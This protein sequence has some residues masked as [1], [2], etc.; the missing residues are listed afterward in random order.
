M[1]DTRMGRTF[2]A[3]RLVHPFPSF[4]N[5]ALVFGLALLAAHGTERPP[6][7]VAGTLAAGMLGLQFC[8]GTVNDLIDEPIDRRAKEWKPIA[9]GIVSRRTATVL[10][11]IAG[12]GGLALAAVAGGLAVLSMAAAMLACGLVYDVWLKPTAWAWLCFS[13]AF[14]ILPVYA[15]F[16]ASGQLPPRPE[17]LLPLAALA[18]PLIQLSNSLADLE[19]DAATG[20]KTLA[21]RL[22]RRGSLAVIAALVVVIHGLAWLTVAQIWNILAIAS[23][24]GFALI[25]LVLAASDQPTRR[26]IGWMVQALAIALLALA[27]VLTE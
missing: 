18:G 14:A 13:V 21:T 20:I 12:G 4:L 26:E 10:A 24:S 7:L 15:W 16:G 2:S 8:I 3:L 22:G 6:F 23:A 1:A 9:A 19:R 25:G 27:W 11:L 5:G 17:F